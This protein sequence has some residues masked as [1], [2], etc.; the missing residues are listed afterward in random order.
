[1]LPKNN[2]RQ[3]SDRYNP[4]FALPN[5]ASDTK[6]SLPS[7]GLLKKP[8]K[9]AKG[10]VGDSLSQAGTQ[11]KQAELRGFTKVGFLQVASKCGLAPPYVGGDNQSLEQIRLQAR[12][13]GRPLVIFP[14][15]TTSNGRG[16]L[17]FENVFKGV[18]VPIEHYNIFIMCVRLV[19]VFLFICSILF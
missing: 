11:R 13:A 4:V 6:P 12:K 18:T 14:E 7:P 10:T 17:R 9:G 8:I 15:C 3:I 2:S 16:L 19:I 1:M 5:F